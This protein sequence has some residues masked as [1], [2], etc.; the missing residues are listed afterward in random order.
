MQSIQD[1]QDT[2]PCSL[3]VCVGGKVVGYV[4]LLEVLGRKGSVLVESLVVDPSMRGRGLG[5][6]LMENAENLARQ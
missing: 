4:R 3:V 5:R 2:L 6:R 1:S